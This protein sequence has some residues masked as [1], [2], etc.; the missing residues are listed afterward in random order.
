MEVQSSTNADSFANYLLGIVF[1]A[2]LTLAAVGASLVA[3]AAFDRLPA[4]PIT[5]VDAL[6]EKLRFLRENGDI[7][8]SLLVVGSSMAWRQFDGKPFAAIL[9]KG[10]V[11][12]GASGLLKVHQTRFLTSFYLAHLRDLQTIML[13][14]GPPDFAN[15][16]AT[17]AELFDPE[18]ASGYA[19]RNDFAAPLYIQYFSPTLY[20]RRALKYH[21][22]LVPLLGELWMDE[23]GSGP[24]QWTPEMIKGLRYDEANLDPACTDSLLALL[25]EIR[26]AGIRPVVVFSPVHPEYRRRY[27]ETM[28]QFKEV[29]ARIESDIHHGID[30]FDM[31]ESD[32][33]DADFFDAV[34]LQWAAV[35]RFSNDLAGLVFPGRSAA[36]VKPESP[37]LGHNAAM[38]ALPENTGP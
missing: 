3:L 30:F 12:N 27:P 28:R 38:P 17:P 36:L 23:Y 7:R 16:R 13:I 21:E 29:G 19:F 18:V 11:L 2:V 10:R 20:F 9:G 32:F 31:S 37:V 4:P 24:M 25:S 6:D 14:L 33:Q 26:Q 1:G 5:S 22:R 35:R 8:P 15:C 34:H